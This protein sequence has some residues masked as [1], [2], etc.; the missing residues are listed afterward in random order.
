ME[1]A[2]PLWEEIRE[3]IS[4]LNQKVEHETILKFLSYVESKIKCGKC[5]NHFRNFPRPEKFST[6]LQVENWFRDLN[7]DIKKQKNKVNPKN[8][9]SN[10]TRS[11]RF[12]KIGRINKLKTK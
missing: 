8:S 12:P 2:K 1:W 4:V 6:N 7:N 11:N 5:K 10:V 3:Y 9:N